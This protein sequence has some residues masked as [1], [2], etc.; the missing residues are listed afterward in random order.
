M[1]VLTTAAIVI[2]STTL[3]VSAAE[4]NQYL[5]DMADEVFS[6]YKVF[7]GVCVL[8]AILSFAYHG[9]E[10]LMAAFMSRGDIELD[11]FKKRIIYMSIALICIVLLPTIIGWAKGFALP[12]AWT[13]P[14]SS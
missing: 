10:I 13:P 8:F 5:N 12:N 14:S 4:T 11:K 9:F 7:R 3:T 1:T 2:S 6:V